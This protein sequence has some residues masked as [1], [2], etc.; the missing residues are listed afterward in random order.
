MPKKKLN[1]ITNYVI[2]ISNQFDSKHSSL[3]EARTY[4]R[5][6][7]NINEVKGLDVVV[8]IFKET[9]SLKKLPNLINQQYDYGTVDKV[10]KEFQ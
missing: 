5:S 1:K 8:D 9:T 4:M 10:F 3:K 6:L 2:M 7:I